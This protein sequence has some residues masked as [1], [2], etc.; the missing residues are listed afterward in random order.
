MSPQRARLS[1]IVPTGSRDDVIEDCLRSVRWAD[2]VIVVDSYSADQ[3]LEIA[4]KYADRVLEHEY[5]FSALQKNWAIP[6]ASHE[7]VLIVDTDERVPAE[8]RDEIEAILHDPGAHVGYRIPRINIVLGKE[9]RQAGYYPDYQVRLFRRD[10]ARYELRRVH[11]HVTLDGSCGTL[12]A[13]LVHYSSRSLDQTLRN[14]LITMTTWEAEQRA[15]SARQAGRRPVRRLWFNL[16]FRPIAAFGLRYFRQ[17]GWRDGYHGLV[18]SLIWAIYVAI[19]YM[20]IWEL[21]L[22]LPDQWWQEDWQQRLSMSGWAK[23][24]QIDFH[25]DGASDRIPAAGG[26]DSRPHSGDYL[27]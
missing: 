15:E 11:A 9:L 6:Q 21:G 1:V 10:A 4:G 22:R 7:W 16:L 18:V 25:A 5:G 23:E 19:T 12:E 17:G 20:K 2:E 27:I 26:R 24:E 14:L 13:P 8:L 3:T